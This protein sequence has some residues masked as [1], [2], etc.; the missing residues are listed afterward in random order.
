MKNSVNNLEE[1]KLLERL[2]RGD[3]AGYEAL[4]HRYYPTFFT[5][6]KGMTKESALAED[7][8]QNIFMKVWIN[9]EKLDAEKS[10]RNYLFVLAKYEVYNYFR[11]KSRLVVPLDGSLELK[12]SQPNETYETIALKDTIDIV[13]DIVNRMPPQR[14]N[15]FRMSRFKQIPNREIAD[16]L[17]LSVR[18]VEK[19]LELAIRELRTHLSA[20]AALLA[21]A[22]FFFTSN[23]F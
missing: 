16:E 5:F 8:T 19:H 9:R 1:H 4:F 10:I 22:D 13:E 11:S 23:P 7:I 18:T 17:N 14:Q 12:A 6:I 15:V 2:I 20:N 3:V 21:V